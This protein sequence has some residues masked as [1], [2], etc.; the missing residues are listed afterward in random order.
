MHRILLGQLTANGDCLYATILARQIRD[1]YPD[2][3]ITWAI[4]SLCAPILRNNPYVDKVWQIP[5]ADRQV[6]EVTWHAF[7]YEALSGYLRR[8]FDDVFLSQIYPSNFQNFDGTVRPSILR[9][10]GRPITVPIENIIDLTSAEKERV[11]LLAR[12][13][14]LAEIEHRIL[15]ECSS[16]SG[17]SF[18]DPD[19]AQQVAELIYQDLPS[20]TVILCSDQPIVV[21][22]CRSHEVSGLSLREVAHLTNHCSVFVGA[23]SGATVAASSTA[24]KPLPMILL[25]DPK[26]SMLASFAHDFEYFQIARP[27]VIELVQSDPAVVADCVRLTSIGRTDAASAAYGGRLHVHFDHYF[28]QIRWG[29]LKQ[30]RYLDAATSL[31]HTAAR[32]GWVRELIEFGTKLVAPYLHEDQRWWFERNRQR[33]EEFWAR[34]ADAA[35][36]PATSPVQALYSWASSAGAPPK[37]GPLS[38]GSLLG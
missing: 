19:F 3:H 35:R 33:G 8:E 34:L 37:P 1:D 18:V 5:M 7:Q 21:K 28:G 15:F 14:R 11:D 30:G 38:A 26:T 9:S 20:A 6:Q 4:S 24:S 23:G 25:L 22:D 31:E 2:A 12:Q 32:Y 13:W 10:Y 16:K 17:Q 29:L 27:P 36:A